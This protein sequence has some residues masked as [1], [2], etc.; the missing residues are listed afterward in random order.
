MKHLWILAFS[1]LLLLSLQSKERQP[2]TTL[3]DQV[4][5]NWHLAASK[6]DLTTYFSYVTDDFIFLGTDPNERW[7]K[8]EFE[9]FC[10]PYFDKGTAWTFT[11]TERN[12]VFS[13]NKKTAWFDEKL[14]TWMSDCR[15][16]GVLVKKGKQWKLAYY[17][18]TV[19]IENDKIKSFI[20]LRKS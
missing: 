16:S 5:D 7:N 10:K 8:K 2:D 13:K 3:L 15:G 9:A 12:W 17:N 20:E 18:L 1:S 11:K 19:V 6:A 4:V 14:D